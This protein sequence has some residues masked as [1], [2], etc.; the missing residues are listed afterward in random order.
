MT[1]TRWVSLNCNGCFC[2]RFAFLTTTGIVL[3]VK[4]SSVASQ[5]NFHIKLQKYKL[6][7]FLQQKQCDGYLNVKWQNFALL[8][9][10]P[11][12]PLLTRL[13]KDGNGDILCFVLTNLAER[14]WPNFFEKQYFDQESESF[15]RSH[16]DIASNQSQIR[17]FVWSNGRT[18][19]TG[20]KMV[21]RIWMDER[22]GYIFLV[23][24]FCV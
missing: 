11:T 10:W 14:N 16:L 18:W 4:E 19:E 22:G 5:C 2:R 24:Y 8:L 9:F 3:H 1:T 20:Q 17:S 15:R 21:F 6:Q 13:Y 7:V 23:I 12:K